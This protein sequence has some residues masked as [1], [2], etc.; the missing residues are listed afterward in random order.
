MGKLSFEER[1]KRVE[2]APKEVQLMV[3]KAFL[4]DDI[5][6]ESV[7]YLFNTDTIEEMNESDVTISD[8]DAPEPEGI[9]AGE[10]FIRTWKPQ[11]NEN[12]T[13]EGSGGWSTCIKGFPMDPTANVLANCVGNASG[14]FNECINE[15]RGTTGCPYPTLC[16]N[17]V[18]FKEA[19]EAAGLQT[20]DT[21]R[22]GAL[23]VWG[24]I[25]G[26]GHVEFVEK[27]YDNNHIFT[28]ASNYGGTTWY[29]ADRYNN[30]GRWGLVE[31]FYFR[32]FI[33]LPDD[34]QKVVDNAINPPTPPTP[35][36]TPTEFQIGDKV[37]ILNGYLTADSYGGGGKTLNY[38][39]D[40]NPNDPVNTKYITATNIGAPRPYH[41]S[42]GQEFGQDNI[43][44]A[45]GEQLKK[46]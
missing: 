30:N 19:A 36:P 21:P 1:I 7:Q 5:D 22:N 11:Y 16:C 29:N 25:N 28:S 17:A 26:A 35:T 9:G 6:D 31:V 41:L 40:T 24:K 13:T 33:Y 10:Y 23:I 2:Q 43:G 4:R 15:A 8:I 42:N 44:W 3:A 18:D 12:F 34:V 37:L 27:A 39:G 32:C 38:D 20:G 46:L 14:R 45:S